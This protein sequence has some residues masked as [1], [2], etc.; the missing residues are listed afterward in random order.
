M[1]F[2]DHAVRIKSQPSTI[3]AAHNCHS[4]AT[5]L[6]SN[7]NSTPSTDKETNDTRIKE[8]QDPY[9]NEPLFNMT[10]L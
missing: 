5:D 7:L 3:N 9:M 6:T 8:Y 10:T 1:K 4:T 2:E